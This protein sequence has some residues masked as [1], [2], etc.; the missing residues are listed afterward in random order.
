[1]F[2]SSFVPFF[3]KKVSGNHADIIFNVS[4]EGMVSQARTE[5]DKC[6]EQIRL[7]SIYINQIALDQQILMKFALRDL[8]NW[9]K[10]S[11]GI[12]FVI[13]DNLRRAGM[14]PED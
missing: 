7:D 9:L 4:D 5:K 8:D 14:D 2:N 11:P 6:R 10:Q 3:N 12:S 13:L 1:M